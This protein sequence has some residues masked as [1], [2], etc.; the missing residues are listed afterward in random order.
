MVK[1][2]QQNKL[3]HV[4]IGLKNVNQRTAQ[5]LLTVCMSRS[6][7]CLSFNIMTTVEPAANSSQ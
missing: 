4:D 5:C 2:Q 7:L 3:L 1:Q 6:A